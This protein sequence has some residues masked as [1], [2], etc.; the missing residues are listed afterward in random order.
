MEPFD[1]SGVLL[2]FGLIFSMR[3]KACL[4]RVW[5]YIKGFRA[6]IYSYVLDFIDT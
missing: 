3:L 4:I 5:F 6:S 1:A 2:L